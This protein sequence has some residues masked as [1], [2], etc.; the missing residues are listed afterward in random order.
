MPG[1]G[2]PGGPGEGLGGLWWSEGLS[3][4]LGEGIHEEFQQE[5][6]GGSMWG[7]SLHPGGGILV[8]FQPCPW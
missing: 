4:C 1:L 6:G 5:S 3:K 8:G 7:C 2:S